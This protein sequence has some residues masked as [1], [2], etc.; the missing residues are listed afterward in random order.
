MQKEVRRWKRDLKKG[1]VT[2]TRDGNLHLVEIFPF[3]TCEMTTLKRHSVCHWLRPY[4][5]GTLK[6]V[7]DSEAEEANEALDFVR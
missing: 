1:E 2:L 6:D 7:A 5:N 3:L 4:L